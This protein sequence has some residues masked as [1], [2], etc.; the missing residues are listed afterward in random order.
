M[1]T[2]IKNVLGLALIL[3]ALA[4]GQ[5]A[6]RLAAAYDR[7]IDPSAVRSFSVSGEGR[8]VVVP[9]VAAVSFGV[10]T[11][12]TADSLKI[13]QAENA[14]AGGAIMNFLKSQGVAEKDVQTAEYS[15]RPVYEE[16]RYQLGIPCPANP[17]ISGYR[18]SQKMSVK[19][20][21]FGKI[22][23][24]LSG[25]VERGANDVSQLS[26]VIDDPAVPEGEARAKAIKQ[27]EEKARAM[28]K[29]A[30]FSVGRLLSINEGLYA[31]YKMYADRAYGLGA[32]G[33][34][35][36]ISTPEIAPGSEE[37]YATVNITYEIR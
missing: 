36:S 15:I 35:T 30:G 29:A 20:R 2:K 14:E 12:A 33:G 24:I 9:D 25:A 21:D 23:D 6:W 26:F 8:V 10:V 7:S 27:A 17:R 11:Q 13:A 34:D 37:V 5:A 18:I 22:G 28:A 4:L 31:P 19:I 1:S 32:G 3:A 16:C